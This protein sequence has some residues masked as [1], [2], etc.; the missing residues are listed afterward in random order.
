MDSLLSFPVGLFH[1]L[2]HTGLSGRTR[3]T[4]YSGLEK[5]ADER[6]GV[7]ERGTANRA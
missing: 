4:D 7:F 1:P 5:N 2:Q 3:F 6:I